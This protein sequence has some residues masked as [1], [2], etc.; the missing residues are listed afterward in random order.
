[1]R[2]TQQSLFR[3]AL[4][5][6]IGNLAALRQAGDRVASGSRIQRLSD[7]PEAVRTVMDLR[8]RL[9]NLDLY[10]GTA[11]LADVRLSA[12]DAALGSVDQLLTQA[13]NLAATATD[14]PD[15]A[16]RDATL[17]EI[18][19]IR[20]QVIDLGN[21]QVSGTYI[22]AGAGSQGPAFAGDGSYVGTATAPVMDLWGGSRVTM[23]HTGDEALSGAI[24]A[25]DGLA[26]SLS[27]GDSQAI[28]ASVQDLDQAARGLRAVRA[29][30]GSRMRSVEE[31]MR[32]V[33]RENTDLNNREQDL[34]GADPTEALL[35]MNEAKTALDR[36]YEAV[37]KVLNTNLLQFLR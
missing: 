1:V 19:A 8:S 2:I 29:Q 9:R 14:N 10:R 28:Q 18:R 20:D 36:A 34:A 13:K 16:M 25:L 32:A 7:D 4:A 22:F 23:N 11:A 24:D 30:T 26:E 12:E 5:G 3:N 17:Q 33:A 31:N 35:K 37:S 15:P 27:G 21:T 6:L